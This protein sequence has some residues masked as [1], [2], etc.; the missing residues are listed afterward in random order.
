MYVLPMLDGILRRQAI[1]ITKG[2]CEAL[3]LTEDSEEALVLS[4]RLT[5][6]AV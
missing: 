4:K 6:L 2:A 3:A 1:E 5:G